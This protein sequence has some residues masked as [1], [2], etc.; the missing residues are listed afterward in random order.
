MIPEFSK[1]FKDISL[2]A[3]MQRVIEARSKTFFEARLG[4]SKVFIH[5]CTTNED[6]PLQLML[7]KVSHIVTGPCD[8]PKSAEFDDLEVLT[9]SEILSKILIRCVT[10]H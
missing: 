8:I 10:W 4:D 6:Q 3:S 9:C 7:Q 2:H 1:F 5:N